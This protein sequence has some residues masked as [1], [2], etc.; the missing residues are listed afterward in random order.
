MTPSLLLGSHPGASGKAHS[1]GVPE[2]RAFRTMCFQP[3]PPLLGK[4]PLPPQVEQVWAPTQESGP[5]AFM[6]TLIDIVGLDRAGVEWSMGR[7]KRSTYAQPTAPMRAS[8]R[9]KDLH[10]CNQVG[11]LR[12]TPSWIRV[13]LVQCANKRDQRG[14]G[15]KEWGH[16]NAETEAGVKQTQ[17]RN[18]KGRQERHCPGCIFHASGPGPG[19]SS[20]NSFSTSQPTPSI[21]RPVCVCVRARVCV[22]MCACVGMC[23]LC[24]YACVH[25]LTSITVFL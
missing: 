9:Q 25:T 22:H 8:A 1:L 18:T 17:W 5:L 2:H 19:S 16:E 23:S 11:D 14:M 4:G 13:T 20:W 21:P 6:V 10:R 12:M 7:P 24:V 15:R 3:H